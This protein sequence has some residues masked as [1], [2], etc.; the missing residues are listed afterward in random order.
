[1]SQLEALIAISAVAY[2]ATM[3]DNLAAYA[4][5]LAIAPIEQHRVFAQWQSAAVAML[6][7]ASVV[8]GSLL[9]VV[10]LAFFA[11]F[12]V[13]P[14]WLGWHAWRQR[15]TASDEPS[16]KRALT[17][18]AVT[19]TLGGDNIAVWAPL[20][21]IHG[22]VGDITTLTTFVGCQAAFILIARSLASHPVVRVR[23][24]RF[25]RAVTPWLYSVLGL[26]IL[27]ECAPF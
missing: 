1:M 20:F 27:V 24:D 8:L 4:A 14:W 5:Q 12:A 23:V 9:H 10:P 25:G 26:V 15:H 22:V 21:R 2:G 11:I 18:F 6:A 16:A 7:A 17:V 3:L 19:L 13:A